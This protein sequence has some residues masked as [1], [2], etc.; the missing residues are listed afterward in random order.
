MSKR[1]KTYPRTT[2]ITKAANQIARAVANQPMVIDRG[3]PYAAPLRTGGF[4]GNLYRPRGLGPELKVIDN[5]TA[6]YTTTTAG[7][8]GLLNGVAQGSDYTNRIG[9]KIMMKSLLFRLCTTPTPG[10]TSSSPKGCTVR[11][12]VFYDHQTNGAPPAVTDI[13]NGATYLQ[14]TN[15][16]NRDRFIILMDKFIACEAYLNA[17][18]VLN[19]GA[20]KTHVLKKYIKMS[21]DVVFQN[22]SNAVADIASGSLYSL[23]IAD[24]TTWNYDVNTRVRFVDA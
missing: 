11:V 17:A 14:P 12:I 10:V 22:T 1:Q 23:I 3:G 21:K 8:L 2:G 5:S 7:A 19:T 6:N 24:N 16:N 13:L 20:P 9:R 18:S 4:F 15:L